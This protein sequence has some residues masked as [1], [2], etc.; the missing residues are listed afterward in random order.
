[1][2]KVY[3]KVIITLTL[4]RNI[5]CKVSLS[6]LYIKLTFLIPHVQS[7]L[8]FNLTGS[9]LGRDYYRLKKLLSQFPAYESSTLVGPDINNVGD[10]LPQFDRVKNN[11]GP[12]VFKC[13]NVSSFL[14]RP[15]AVLYT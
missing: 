8:G 10:C 13:D 3:Q 1:M 5:L 12:Y 2:L 14:K 15:K 6:L 11:N 9:Q 4:G 7:Q